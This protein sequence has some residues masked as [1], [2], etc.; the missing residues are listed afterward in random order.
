MLP[1]TC[2]L[3]AGF[4]EFWPFAEAL[5]TGYPLPQEFAARWILAQSSDELTLND[6]DPSPI[7]CVL[8]IFCSESSFMRAAARRMIA[9]QMW[10]T[11]D[12]DAALKPIVDFLSSTESETAWKEC[13]ELLLDI[14][15]A[16]LFRM[17]CS[18]EES[19]RNRVLEFV[20]IA[21]DKVPLDIFRRWYKEHLRPEHQ[22]N[23]SA[24]QRKGIAADLLEW[25]SSEG[26][27][28]THGPSGHRAAI[29]SALAEAPNE[30]EEAIA[31]L[32]EIMVDDPNM[33]VVSAA[34]SALIEHYPEHSFFLDLAG[35]LF[36]K[37]FPH[38]LPRL[39]RSMRRG[40]FVD[41][42]PAPL[43]PVLRKVW[44]DPGKN[45]DIL[46][47]RTLRILA[48]HRVS[49]QIVLDAASLALGHHRRTV[50]HAALKWFD[51][52]NEN[53][54]ARALAEAIPRIID[55]RLARLAGMKAVEIA[56]RAID[57]TSAVANATCFR[58]D[59]LKDLFWKSKHEPRIADEM[60]DAERRLAG[61]CV[62]Y[63]SR[64]DLARA[65]YGSHLFDSNPIEIYGKHATHSIVPELLLAAT[66]NLPGNVSDLLAEA[67]RGGHP[68]DLRLKH[69]LLPLLQSP[70][71]N[72]ND[73]I[74]KLSNSSWVQMTFRAIA[75]SN[76]AKRLWENDSEEII[77][78]FLADFYSMLKR[79]PRSLFNLYEHYTFF[80]WL[81]TVFHNLVLS[82]QRRGLSYRVRRSDIPLHELEDEY[83]SEE[84]KRIVR[85]DLVAM[86]FGKLDPYTLG[87]LLQ[88]LVYKV[89]RKQLSQHYGISV[90][91]LRGIEERAIAQLK[92]REHQIF[93]DS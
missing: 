4:Q 54:G 59:F 28:L 48:K 15:P 41:E 69:S 62:K 43:L 51:A 90:E 10:T 39:Y 33:D 70:K 81:R 8:P 35:E 1:D 31:F 40:L 26:M 24:P 16:V 63:I 17:I 25:L 82:D 32:V 38:R 47:T 44:N 14:R 68:D 75:R 45:T 61:F 30:N 53:R 21:I 6:V 85:M 77:S 9:S 80:G 65:V 13:V 76:A 5:I 67:D 73:I 11:L 2:E 88:R 36:E 55:D 71:D 86:A 52:T 78:C 3:V 60:R 29:A 58:V 12:C 83:S 74:E 19:L 50:V 18:P 37:P 87:I 64:D 49:D 46:D 56:P 84:Q 42:F 57:V 93:G 22:V 20:K 91:R 23:H 27:R 72:A 92:R 7:F 89:P 34:T 66:F 79:S